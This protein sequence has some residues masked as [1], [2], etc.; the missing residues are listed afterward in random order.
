MGNSCC[1]SSKNKPDTKNSTN[2][3]GSFAESCCR[4][5]SRVIDESE[6]VRDEH[7]MAG[8]VFPRKSVEKKN[9]E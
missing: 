1:G 8:Y 4:S 7:P 6:K 5:S 3:R 9:I 2:D